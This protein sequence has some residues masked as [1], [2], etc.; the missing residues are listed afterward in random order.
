MAAA[1][2]GYVLVPQ[3]TLASLQPL[4]SAFGQG[5]LWGL[6]QGILAAIMLLVLRKD[7][8][9]ILA[10][11]IGFLFYLFA[12]YMTTRKGGSFARGAWAGLWSGITSTVIFWIVLAIGLL[13]LV[14]QRIQA[15]RLAAQEQGAYIGPGELGYAFRAVAP[16]FLI[17]SRLTTQSPWAP[18]IAYC[19][20]GL[21]LAI[22]F[23]V[24]GGILG[25]MKH[26][27]SINKKKSP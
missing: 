3:T 25:T 17:S 19:V 20:A 13:V 16:A 21:T 15:D 23:C 18:L 2:P 27:D 1:P 6:I 26:R 14:S 11:L 22:I 10:T 5:C 7:V 8:Y 24:C 4:P 12:G 9:F